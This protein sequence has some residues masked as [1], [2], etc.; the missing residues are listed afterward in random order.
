MRFVVTCPEK[1]DPM[2]FAVGAKDAGADYLEIRDDLT[3]SSCELRGV[4]EIIPLM[5]S[6]RLEVPLPQEWI[7]AAALVDEEI[8]LPG[9][10]AGIEAG[11]VILSHHSGT[12]LD[13]DEAYEMWRGLRIDGE[14]IKHVEPYTPGCEERLLSLQR[15]LMAVSSRVTVLA[16]GAQALEL[17]RRLSARNH[18]HYCALG[19]DTQSAEGQAILAEEMAILASRGRGG[20]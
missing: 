15:R 17:R 20:R 3:E 10:R 13:I 1:T 2:R 11:R 5:V 19:A 8:S 18:L 6:R 12:P 14:A 9:R 4:L 16:T 7:E